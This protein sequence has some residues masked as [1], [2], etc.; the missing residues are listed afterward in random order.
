[1]QGSG[2]VESLRRCCS[3]LHRATRGLGDGGGTGLSDD[4]HDPSKI[5]HALRDT[6]RPLLHDKPTTAISTQPIAPSSSACAPQAPKAPSSLH[7]RCPLSHRPTRNPPRGQDAQATSSIFS[8]ERAS[9][10]RIG[11]ALHL[12]DQLCRFLLVCGLF[13]SLPAWLASLMGSVK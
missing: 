4:K 7:C 13:T 12:L 11:I 1:M 10:V 8:G 3:G 5:M 9:I 2:R 6:G